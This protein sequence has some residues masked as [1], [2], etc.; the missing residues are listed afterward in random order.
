MQVILNQTTQESWQMKIHLKRH[1]FTWIK[2][3]HSTHYIELY[4]EVTLLPLGGN[5]EI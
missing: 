3:Y 2:G 1:C 4:F 5:K